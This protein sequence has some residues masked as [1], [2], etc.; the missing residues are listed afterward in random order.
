MNSKYGTHGEFPWWGFVLMA[1]L[2]V[3]WAVWG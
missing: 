1:A 2:V 3:A